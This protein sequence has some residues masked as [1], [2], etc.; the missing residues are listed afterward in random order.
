MIRE[1]IVQ[2]VNFIEGAENQYSKLED[3]PVGPVILLGDFSALLK[4][5]PYVMADSGQHL[6]QTPS[7]RSTILHLPRLTRSSAYPSIHLYP[8][9]TFPTSPI[10][11]VWSA[12]YVHRV[13]SAWEVE[14]EPDR[15]RHACFCYFT[16]R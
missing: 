9:W 4:P 15:F 5:T 12:P 14:Y 13:R 16:R 1:H 7:D 11:S 2:W 8:I 6:S 10:G 3:R